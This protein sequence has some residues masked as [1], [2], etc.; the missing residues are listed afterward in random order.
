VAKTP[1][2]HP[3]APSAGTLYLNSPR[4]G[5]SRPTAGPVANSAFSG[6]GQHCEKDTL[7]VH[8]GGHAVIQW[9]ENNPGFWFFHCH[10]EWHLATGM[11]VVIRST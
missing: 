2:P 8:A 3:S 5:N 11:A 7:S 4:L 9:K 6:D 10:I 1:D